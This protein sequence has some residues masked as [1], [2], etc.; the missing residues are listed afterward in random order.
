ME[1]LS[2]L[3]GIGPVFAWIL[4]SRVYR[5]YDYLDQRHW[6]R[7]TATI[8]FSS[9]VSLFPLL[10]VVA[11]IAA[12]LLSDRDRARLEGWITDQVPGIADSLDL[13]SLFSNAGTVGAIAFAALL[14]TGLNWVGNLRDCLRAVWDRDDK[15]ENLFFGKAKDAR[16]M[17]GLGGAVLGSVAL[18]VATT[19]ASEKII[20]ALGLAAG[21]VGA[22]LLK[23][24][25][26]AAAVVAGV[27][28]LCYALIRLPDI[29]VE[30]RPPRREVIKAA[31]AGAVGFELL[32]LL[33][34]GYLS[35]VAAKSIYGAFGVPVAL[36]LWLSFMARLLLYCAGWTAAPRD[37]GPRP[38]A[39]DEH[40]EQRD[41]GQ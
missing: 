28:I 39:L 16:L 30:I 3:P 23:I 38:L 34:S 29:P 22:W 14:V 13:D 10:T 31:L 36:V 2:R 35:S 4:R 12:T 18:S 20:E 5:V 19:T 37:V 26:F 40:G 11:A 7:L 6:N 25:A 27:L 21:G 17:A 9:F 8:T 41:D 33:L 24:A 1:W 32:K 15:G